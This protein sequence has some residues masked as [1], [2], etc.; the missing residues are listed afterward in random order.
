M[1]QFSKVLAVDNAHTAPQ[2]N[3]VK[4]ELWTM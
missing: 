1:G 4:D 2:I 3:K